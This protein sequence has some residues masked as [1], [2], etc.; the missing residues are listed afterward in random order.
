MFKF[1]VRYTRQRTVRKHKGQIPRPTS[2]THI[3]TYTCLEE[4][5]RSTS[6]I[7]EESSPKQPVESEGQLNETKSER[8]D[9]ILRTEMEPRL[10]IL[11]IVPPRKG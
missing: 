10:Q 2:Y 4:L 9:K 3:Y 5:F 7:R 1:L 6:S 11:F 8:R